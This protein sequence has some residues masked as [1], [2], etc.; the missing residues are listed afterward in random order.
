MFIKKVEYYHENIIYKN[1]SSIIQQN[2]NEFIMQKVLFGKTK[3]LVDNNF[4][5]NKIILKN[6]LNFSKNINSTKFLI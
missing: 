3:I 6:L 2:Y 4:F 1:S 5:N